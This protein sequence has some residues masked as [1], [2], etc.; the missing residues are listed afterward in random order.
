LTDFVFVLCPVNVNK[1][2]AG[3]G[4]VRFQTVEPANARQDQ[5]LG[6]WQWIVRFERNAADENR[7]G[8]H[9]LT[10]LI[11][12]AKLA[13][14]RFIAALFVAEPKARS[15]YRITADNFAAPAQ[16]QFLVAHG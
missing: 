7:A 3:V 6:R 16:L 13:Q 8:R 10:K 15:G 12:N 11:A 5:I 4:I 14:R 2:I 1:T 9:G